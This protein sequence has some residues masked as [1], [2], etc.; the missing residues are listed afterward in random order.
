MRN[1]ANADYQCPF[2]NGQC[3]KPGHILDGPYPV[4]SIRQRTNP[5]LITVC[6]KRFLENDLMADVV[7]HCWPGKP[8][9]N[10]RFAHEI[11]MAPFGQVDMVVADYNAQAHSIREFVSVELQAVD[12]TGSVEPAYSA[13]LNSEPEVRAKYGLNWANVRKR[14]IDQLVAKCFYHHQWNTRVVAVMQSPLYDYFRTHMQFDE[15][16]PGS[17]TVDVAFLLYDYVE[18]DVHHSLVFDRV[19]GTSHNSLMLSTLYQKT[20]PK[21]DFERRILERLQ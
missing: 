20:P 12:I 19:V 8:P 4:C 15:I 10:P 16:A 6:P 7:A 13:L 21:A 9:K 5:R 11:R 14:Y 3:V 1:P 18:G 17:G 2:I